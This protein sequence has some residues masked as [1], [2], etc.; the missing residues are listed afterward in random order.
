MHGRNAHK[1]SSRRDEERLRLFDFRKFRRGRKAFERRRERG[2][3][4]GGA[5]GRLI[6]LRQASRR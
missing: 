1:P 6:K 4:V 5:V 3:G 2:M